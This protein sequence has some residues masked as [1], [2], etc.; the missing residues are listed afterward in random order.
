MNLQI[1]LLETLFLKRFKVV[2][3]A[4]SV[5]LGVVFG[6]HTF[7]R[8][9][10]PMLQELE[11]LAYDL[12]LKFNAPHSPEDRLVLVTIDE[13]SLASIGRWPWP[14]NVISDLIDRLAVDYQ[15]AVIGLDVLLP[16]AE[17]E[18][19]ND[20]E[21]SQTLKKS[22]VVLASSFHSFDDQVRSGSLVTELDVPETSPLIS[23]VPLAIGFIA[24]HER[25]AKHAG[26]G[27]IDN[28]FVS[29]D[30]VFRRLP[31]LQKFN[32]KLYPSFALEI[33]RH[34]VF[35]TQPALQPQ[36][37]DPSVLG[38]V[39]VGGVTIP[40]DQDSAVWINY[41]SVHRDN[42]QTVAAVDILTGK[43]PPEVIE[44]KIVLVGATAVGL[45]D[46]RPT[47]IRPDMPGLEIHAT[48]LAS[49]LDADFLAKPDYAAVG[50]FVVL[51]ILGGYI[52]VVLNVFSALYAV[53]LGLSGLC[54]FLG[55]N[56]FIFANWGLV[57]PVA[58]T[59]LFGVLL[60]FSLVS[61]RFVHQT[62]SKNRIT[63][64]FGQYVPPSVVRD[65][66]RQTRPI[67]L[68]GEM[69]D[70]SVMFVDVQGFT[71]ISETISAQKLTKFLNII[72]GHITSVAHETGGTVDKYIGDAA[73]LFW[74]APVDQP[75]HA[76]RA[77]LTAERLIN[78]LDALNA[79]LK[80]H[81]LPMAQF[82]IGISSGQANVGNMGSDFRMAYTAI[83]QTVNLAARLQS[84]AGTLGK[85][86]LI[87]E[88]TFEQANKKGRAMGTHRLKGFV[89]PV[90]VYSFDP[91]NN[92]QND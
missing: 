34:Y 22:P 3:L 78:G 27:F 55:F 77:V 86:I 71:K 57:L 40:V 10:L 64:I 37:S 62:M 47:P 9:Q 91:P 51:L 48:I 50:S 1:H 44:G 74:G 16:E 25:F 85:T 29:S 54:V 4:I 46:V 8:I 84:L 38:S 12:R 42:F 73:M 2:S 31:L 83:G 30:G 28:P 68:Q 7:Q 92:Y 53:A 69:R 76:H 81:G 26:Q 5:L 24:P 17:R 89:N 87:S 20:A 49:F 82:T 65:L 43:I 15:A 90:P 39:M 75:D 56:W 23:S 60:T 70:I 19:G 11:H 36:H 72:L 88:Q 66:A 52:F 67:S 61:L 80:R 41:K 6:L 79:Q 32:G 63:K 14:R 35:R 21:L 13:K 59:F 33:W 45:N 18:L 58:D